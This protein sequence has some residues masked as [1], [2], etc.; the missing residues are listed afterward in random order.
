MNGKVALFNA[1]KNDSGVTSIVSD[2]GG[3]V[4]AIAVGIVEP[5]TWGVDL[6]TILIYDPVGV[7]NT[8]DWLSAD[9]TVNCRAQTFGV[10]ESLAQAV[11]NAVNRLPVV[12]G[13]RYYCVTGFMIEPA[14]EN[15]NYNLPVSVRIR[16]I[17]GLD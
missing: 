14:N 5:N 6:T 11:V 15:D 4:P 2:L 7:D 16:S 9:V 3:G 1:L 10:A 8:L 12:G 13:G 17:R